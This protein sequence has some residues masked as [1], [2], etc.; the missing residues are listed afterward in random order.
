MPA[1]ETFDWFKR[2]IW[3]MIDDETRSFLNDQRQYL[4]NIRNEDERRR[5]TEEIM[6]A[7]RGNRRK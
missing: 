7:V 3:P 1:L 6:K 4:L 5:F 2:Q